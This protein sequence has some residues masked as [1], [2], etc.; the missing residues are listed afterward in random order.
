MTV[1]APIF[2]IEVAEEATAGPMTNAGVTT[3]HAH[4]RT[5]PALSMVRDAWPARTATVA[6]FYQMCNVLRAR[7][8]AT[9]LSNV[10]CLPLP[11]ALNGT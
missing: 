4:H 8:S 10:T 7:R 3:T 6:L 1:L 11:Y 9:W 2:V 5:G